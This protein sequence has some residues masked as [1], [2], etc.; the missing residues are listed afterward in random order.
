MVSLLHLDLEMR[1]IPKKTP[2]KH[3]VMSVDNC[4]GQNKHNTVINY[5]MWLTE[6]GYASKETL[7]FLIKG[8]T[9]T[10]AIETSI[11][12]RGHYVR[13]TFIAIRVWMQ[14]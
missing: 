13:R 5:S 3:I 14:H 2:V 4:P 6:A 9:E 10:S 7:L 12:Y 11:F 8:H 1:G